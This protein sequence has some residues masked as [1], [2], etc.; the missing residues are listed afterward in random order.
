MKHIRTLGWPMACALL[1]SLAAAPAGARP[2][3]WVGPASDG[4]LMVLGQAKQPGQ[5]VSPCA[6]TAQAKGEHVVL[7]YQ[8][9]MGQPEY[10]ALA[11]DETLDLDGVGAGEDTGILAQVLAL[12]RDP[13]QQGHYGGKRLRDADTVAGFPDGDL[14]LPEAASA[15]TFSATRAG[16]E[17]IDRVTVH[18]RDDPARPVFDGAAPD[19]TA[20]V[21][22][23]ALRPGT[24][25]RWAVR[26]GGTT[27]TGGFTVADA[28]DQREFE[29]ELNQ[30]GGRSAGSES[31]RH[32]L[33]AVLAKQYGFTYDMRLALEA[34]RE[35]RR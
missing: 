7:F 11:N 26:A 19:G 28:R 10:R 22:S 32:L 16:L 30:L 23:D 6:G 35:G 2:D 17:R 1:A 8:N 14:L 20:A 21:P 25:Y 13:F 31:D 3:C 27:Y 4:P 29:A 9:R 24:A 33:R 15:L 12:L 5:V 34:A 18:A